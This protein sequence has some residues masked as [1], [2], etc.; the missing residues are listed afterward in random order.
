[1]KPIPVALTAFALISALF[2]FDRWRNYSDPQ[3][4]ANGY[5]IK[6]DLP[7][8][9]NRLSMIVTAHNTACDVLGGDSAVYVYV[10]SSSVADDRRNLVFRYFDR[11]DMAPPKIEWTDDSSVLIAVSHVSQVTKQLSMMDG[12]K[13]RYVIGAEDYPRKQ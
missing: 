3:G 13:I 5:C 8:V 12:I 4:E 11:Y 7:P 10:H 2:I 9:Q 1:M 6:D